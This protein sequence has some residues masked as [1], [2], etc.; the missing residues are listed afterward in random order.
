MRVTRLGD[1]DITRNCNPNKLYLIP[2]RDILT[3]RNEKRV[4]KFTILGAKF[5]IHAYMLP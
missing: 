4:L 5:K 1:Q 3:F 2:C